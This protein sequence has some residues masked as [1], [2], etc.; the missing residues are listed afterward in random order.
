VTSFSRK[1]VNSADQLH[2]SKNDVPE[3]K[4]TLTSKKQS[5]LKYKLHYRVA[6]SHCIVKNVRVFLLTHGSCHKGPFLKNVHQNRKRLTSFPM[7]KNL[8]TGSTFPP[9]SCE[10]TINFKKSKNFCSKKCGL[11]EESEPA[12][13][14][15]KS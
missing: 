4:A 12:L 6:Y 8:R 11:C 10:N 13:F 14:L 9:F 1:N 15:A 7:S 5:K 3:S 2:F